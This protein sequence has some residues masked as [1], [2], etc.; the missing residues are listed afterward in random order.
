MEL[1]KNNVKKILG[2]IT[3]T[4]VLLAFLTNLKSVSEYVDF[5]WGILFPFVLGGT[6][7]FILNIPMSALERAGARWK[8]KNS[9]AKKWKEKLTRPISMVLSILFVFFLINVVIGV[10]VPQLGKTVDS[11][12]V[13]MTTALPKVQSWLEQVFREQE[14]VVAFISSIDFDWK[15]WLNSVKDFA[16]SGAGNVLSYTMSATM[17]VVNGVLTFFIAFVFAL[18]ILMQKEN[19][20]RQVHKLITAIFPAK[21]VERVTYICALANKTFSKFITGQ[22]IEALILGTMFFVS[23][24]I[25]RLPYA[26][27]VGVLISFT[28]LIPMVGAFIGCVVGALLILMVNPMQA[29]IFVILFFVLQQVE[30]NLI[31]PHVVGGSV[32]LPSIWVLFAVTVGGKLMG[33]AGM[34]VFI[35][36]VSV[37]YTLLREWM[38][39]RLERKRKKE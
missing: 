3:F 20:G 24:L 18:Y 22:C 4:L 38:N 28:A 19:L 36:L 32:G 39:A 1:N 8:V 31:Y 11:V 23:M 33:V 37:I 6:I 2:I 14:E 26:M 29:L 21:V 25:L 17:I 35:P 5:L 13:A 7:A 10:V 27:M 30:G 12:G 34:L 15:T 9:R 16:L